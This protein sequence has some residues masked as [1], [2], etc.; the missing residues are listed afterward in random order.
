LF[1]F[2]ELKNSTK[3]GKGA[4]NAIGRSVLLEDAF[5]EKVLFEYLFLTG[6]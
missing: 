3:T 4:L 5:F 2:W 6:L 1:E